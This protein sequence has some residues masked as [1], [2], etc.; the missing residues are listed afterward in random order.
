MTVWDQPTPL[1][2]GSLR[3]EH[4]QGCGDDHQGE[5]ATTGPVMAND[6][7]HLRSPSNSG[8]SGIP[9]VAER[10]G[11]LARKR[12]MPAL[13]GTILISLAHCYD[14]MTLHEPPDRSGLLLR[15]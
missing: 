13:S 10:Y 14:G 15:V 6:N 7:V 1:R 9:E 11:R 4:A 8:Q 5:R 3:R 2:R 12:W